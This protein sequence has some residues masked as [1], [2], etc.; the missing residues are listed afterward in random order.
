M[1]KFVKRKNIIIK[2]AGT[3]H[4]LGGITGPILTPFPCDV[5]TIL[6]LLI[7]HNEVYEV[8][9]DGR[10]IKLDRKNYNKEIDAEPKRPLVKE[11]PVLVSVQD[12]TVVLDAETTTTKSEQIKEFKNN[13]NRNDKK[14]KN[15]K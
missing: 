4:L 13:K 12:E 6:Q 9:K 3:L 10:H 5:D 11:E 7:T 2:S 1:A 8:T 15:N 14:N